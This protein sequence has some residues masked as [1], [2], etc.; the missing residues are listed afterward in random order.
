MVPPL[1]FV[2]R[3]PIAFGLPSKNFAVFYSRSIWCEKTKTVGLKENKD[4]TLTM[5]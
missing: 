4:P 2:N 5:F 1:K 3:L